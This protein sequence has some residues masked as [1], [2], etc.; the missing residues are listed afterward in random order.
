MT[1]NTME[2]VSAGRAQ[3]RVVV[4]IK[5]GHK[6]SMAAGASNGEAVGIQLNSNDI[7][8]DKFMITYFD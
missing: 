5:N 3:S 4:E 2:H 7:E 1:D 6:L 8:P